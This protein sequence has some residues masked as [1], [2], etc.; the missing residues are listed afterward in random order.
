MYAVIS[1]RSRQFTVK[2]NDRILCDLGLAK[3]PGEAVEF[4]QVLL[5]GNEGKLKVG[6]PFV[7]GAR[8]IGEVVKDTKGPKLVVF[9]YKR[10]KNMRRKN[11]HRQGYTEVLIKEIK[12]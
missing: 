10:R 1:D 8:V 7:S 3:Q 12:G 5:L 9:K 11:G 6:A 4:S 2:P